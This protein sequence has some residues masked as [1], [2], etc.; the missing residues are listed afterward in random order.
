MIWDILEKKISDA[1]L[2]VVGETLFRFTMSPEYSIG[3]MLKQPLIGVANDPYMPGWHRPVLQVVV[4]HNDP[5]EG[6]A[7]ALAVQQ[8][9]R[10]DGP[11][12]HPATSTRGAVQISLFFPREYPI[13]FPRQDGRTIEWSLNFVTA[14]SIQ[15]L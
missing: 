6:E 13:Q 12:Q 3:V 14:F 4:R 10:V 8:T 11:E 5:V 2:A 1:G 9:L 15:P 7:L